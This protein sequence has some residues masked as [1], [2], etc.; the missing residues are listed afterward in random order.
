LVGDQYTGN[1]SIISQSGG[2]TAK[3]ITR[4]ISKGVFIAKA[5]S[6]GNAIDL[7]PYDFLP[8]FKKDPDT[9]AVGFYLESTKNGKKL[10][11][12]LKKTN[13]K[14]PVVIW[15]GGQG[16]TGYKAT[17]SHTGELAGNYDLW[18]AACKQSGTI[19]AEDFDSFIDI[20]TCF[21]FNMPMPK[22]LN[23][24]LIACGGGN[25]V[26]AADLFES[27]G[28]TIPPLKEETKK[29]IYK[30]I[31]D[32][33]TSLSNPVDLGEYGYIPQ[34]F[35]NAI[36]IVANDTNID[37]IVYIKESARFPMF[38]INFNMT[39]ENYER[40]TVKKLAKMQ[41]KN[42]ENRNIPLY[43]NDPLISETPEDFKWRISFKEKL[44]KVGIP[45]FNR[46]DILAKTVKKIHEYQQFL[47]KI[48]E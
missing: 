22:S 33:N 43:L 29:K 34:Y 44:G 5:I 13:P 11:N 31:P 4:L 21:A 46:I 39:P 36:N 15:K 14:K 17:A 6:I 35:A 12:N 2:H 40:E 7:Q 48:Q 3:I 24:A 19:L 28:F 27:M 32:I 20:L 42:K 1:I 47:E 16:N 9:K 38:S 37:S 26:E 10:L 45:V 41:K 25:A 30:F 23:V 18:K 8:Y